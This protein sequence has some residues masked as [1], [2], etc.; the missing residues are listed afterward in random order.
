MR[1]VT[2]LHK[3]PIPPHKAGAPNVDS[4]DERTPQYRERL[5]VPVVQFNASSGVALE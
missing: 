1:G 3:S 5:A 4:P 2:P